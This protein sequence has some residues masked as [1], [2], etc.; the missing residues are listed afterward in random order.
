MWANRGTPPPVCDEEQNGDDQ[1][2]QRDATADVGNVGQDGLVFRG[3]LC[4]HLWR[5]R[6]LIYNLVLL[7]QYHDKILKNEIVFTNCVHKAL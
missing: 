2:G 7:W 1:S 5:I 6:A 4:R 3:E